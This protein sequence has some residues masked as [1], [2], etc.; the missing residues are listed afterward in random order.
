MRIAE[1]FE[2]V[3]ESGFG[4][5]EVESVRGWEAL[6]AVFEGLQDVWAN[7]GGCPF[8]FDKEIDAA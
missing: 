4:G 6:G 5:D 3:G 2:G 8:A 1:I 7:G